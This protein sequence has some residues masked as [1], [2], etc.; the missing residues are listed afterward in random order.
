MTPLPHNNTAIYYVDYSTVFREH[1]LEVRANA[2]TSPSLFGSLM[3]G[4]FS[5]IATILYPLTVNT[6]RFQA[7]GTNV[8]NPVITGIEGNL[9]GTGVPTTDNVPIALNFVGRSTGGR[10]VRLMVFGFSGGFSGYRLTTGESNPILVATTVLNGEANAFLAIDGVAPVWYP[11]ANVL[12]NAY[13]QRQVRA[14]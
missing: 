14:G 13:W 5:S 12:A 2:A 4:F 10:R 9:Y 7:I 11:Y 1:T 8:S 3:D 6:V